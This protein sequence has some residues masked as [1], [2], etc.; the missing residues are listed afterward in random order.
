MLFVMVL[1][2]IR[3]AIPTIDRYF[4]ELVDVSLG[5]GGS[6]SKDHANVTVGIDKGD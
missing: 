1:L 4:S 5:R 6:G 3:A 2:R